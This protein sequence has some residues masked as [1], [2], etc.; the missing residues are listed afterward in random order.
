MTTVKGKKK[1]VRGTK[2]AATKAASGT[3]KRKAAAG[4]PEVRGEVVAASEQ[5]VSM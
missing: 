4:N 3:K 5:Q 2:S 1:T